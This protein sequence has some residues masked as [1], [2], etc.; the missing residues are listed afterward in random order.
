M[1]FVETGKDGHRRS[2]LSF[3]YR[4]E[5]AGDVARI[6]GAHI[7]RIRTILGNPANKKE[8]SAFQGFVEEL[9]DDLN[10]AVTEEEVIEMLAQH[11]ITQPVFEAL[12]QCPMDESASSQSL[13]TRSQG[14]VTRSQE[15][16]TSPG[17]LG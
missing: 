11:L 6:A 5:W 1:D 3:T 17:R 16:G 12:F 9:R 2:H 4:E 10:P 14:S 8:Q 13:G 15:P 7:T